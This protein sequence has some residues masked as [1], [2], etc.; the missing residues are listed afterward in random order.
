GS[1]GPVLSHQVA[2]PHLDDDL[3]VA[4]ETAPTPK[5][6]PIERVLQPL[7]L[8]VAG[9]HPAAKQSPRRGQPL[10]QVDL[11]VAAG[12]QQAGGGERA[13]GPGA[14]DRHSRS[15]AGHQAAVRSAVL[16]SA[17]NSALT[18]STYSCFSGISKSAKIAST[19]QAS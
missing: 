14:D 11:D 4:H 3:H 9:S 12:P 18:S 5:R 19:G 1:H 13:R 16:S 15:R 8:L 7:D 17:K 6:L 2:V 10:E